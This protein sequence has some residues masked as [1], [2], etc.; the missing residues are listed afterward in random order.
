MNNDLKT[1]LSTL[2]VALE[3]QGLGT[4]ADTIKDALAELIRL[5]RYAYPEQSYLPKKGA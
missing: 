5:E 1:K 2:I 4:S 3:S